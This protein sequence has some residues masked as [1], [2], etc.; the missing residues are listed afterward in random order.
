MSECAFGEFRFAGTTCCVEEDS[1]DPSS[2]VSSFCGIIFE[3][4]STECADPCPTKPSEEFSENQGCFANSLCNRKTSFFCAETLEGF[5]GARRQ[6]CDGLN[7]NRNHCSGD[8]DFVLDGTMKSG[9]DQSIYIARPSNCSYDNH[10]C[11]PK[12]PYH[13]RNEPE[14]ISLAGQVIQRENAFDL[15]KMDESSLDPILIIT[16]FLEAALA[17]GHMRAP[18]VNALRIL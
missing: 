18:F 6:E 12:V 13:Y 2:I 5:S 10:D 8:V 7:T 14:C 15:E 9:M 4:I 11:S 3:E 16:D 17:I 1:N